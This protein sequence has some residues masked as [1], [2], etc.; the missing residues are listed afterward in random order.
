LQLA[1]NETKYAQKVRAA[2]AIHG[3]QLSPD[4][5]QIA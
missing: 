1:R 4:Y 3:G 5:P 2:V